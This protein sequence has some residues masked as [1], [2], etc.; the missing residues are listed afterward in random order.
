MKTL[1]AWLGEQS[2]RASALA[3]ELAVA[4]SHLSQVRSGLRKIPTDWMPTIEAFSDGVLTIEGMV[5]HQARGR[6]AERKA[7]RSQS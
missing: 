3:R 1:D 7:R 6:I 5:L 4:R 2:G